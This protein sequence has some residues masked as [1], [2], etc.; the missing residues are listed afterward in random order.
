MKQSVSPAVFIG[1]IVVVV[2]V[3]CFFGF[4]AL[5]SGSGGANL[6]PAQSRAKTMQA[7]QVQQANMQKAQE[8][9]PS[10]AP[11]MYQRYKQM[12]GMH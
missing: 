1:A 4:R 9:G 5:F 12:R 7:M 11:A 3:A 2:V 6:S 10:N 8:E